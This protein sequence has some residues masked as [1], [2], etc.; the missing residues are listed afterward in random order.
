MSQVGLPTKLTLMS[1]G[2]R[3]FGMEYPR[4]NSCEREE[5]KQD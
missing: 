4:I 5:R 1:F 2:Y 3:M